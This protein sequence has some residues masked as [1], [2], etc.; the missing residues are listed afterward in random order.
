MFSL[1]A[2]TSPCLPSRTESLELIEKKNELRSTLHAFSRCIVGYFQN[3][4]CLKNNEKTCL[5]NN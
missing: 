2:T 4:S 1:M 5:H 3:L